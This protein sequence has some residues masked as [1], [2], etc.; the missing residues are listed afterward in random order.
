MADRHHALQRVSEQPEVRGQQSEVFVDI[1][2]KVPYDSTYIGAHEGI[3]NFG[4]NGIVRA[5]VWNDWVVI[6]L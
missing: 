4:G 5:F 1:E 2:R 3:L 6:F